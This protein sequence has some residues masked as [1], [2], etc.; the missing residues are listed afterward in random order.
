MGRLSLWFCIVENVFEF[1]M[2][3]VFDIKSLLLHF[4]DQD[5]GSNEVVRLTRDLNGI[6]VRYDGGNT[7]VRFQGKA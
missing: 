7:V 4:S 5:L 3:E 2:M 6:K 1:I